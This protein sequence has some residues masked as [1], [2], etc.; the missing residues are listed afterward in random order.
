MGMY[1]KV[2]KKSIVELEYEAALEDGMA[3]LPYFIDDDFPIPAKYFDTGE[4]ADKLRRFKDRIKSE[5]LVKTFTGPE[6]LA[7]KIVIDLTYY[8]RKP[9]NEAAEDILARPLL[10][11]ELRRCK[12]D[13]SL[14]ASTIN[15]LRKRLENIVPA[16]PIWI[17][18]D[19]KI[20]DTLG[21]VL[22][23]FQERFFC[24]YEDA[25][26]PALNSAGL[27]GMHA[28]EVF[29]NRE[30]VED[31]WES[32]SK[33]RLIIADV[34][35]RNPNV[36]YELGICHT[37][38]KEVIVLTQSS[39]DV[40]FDIRHRRFIEYDTSKLTSLKTRLEKTVKQVLVRTK[41]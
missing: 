2:M 21:F 20:D 17:S 36:F 5:K 35:G 9:M 18:R 14:Y 19:F 37:L 38:G 8:Y 40:P 31:I 6:D 12:E 11:Q 28:G 39:A 13:S 4:N 10:E 22:M 3:V 27:R 7:Q 41:Q 24:V 26:Q 16:E 32:I 25:I 1:L 30:I 33:A 23:P 34:T 15:A 29:D